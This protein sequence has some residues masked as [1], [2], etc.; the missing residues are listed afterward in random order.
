MNLIR[1]LC[2]AAIICGINWNCNCAQS[3]EWKQLFNAK[4]LGGW[5]KFL[6][7]KSGGYHDPKTSKERAL[8]LNNDPQGVFTVVQKDGA[9]AIR[10]SGE[11]F[12]AITTKEA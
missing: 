7:P 2:L 11:V 5:D 3:E 12:G 8:G 1:S 6:G 9:G 4:D 10:V